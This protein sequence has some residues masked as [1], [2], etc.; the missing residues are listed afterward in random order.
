LVSINYVRL[1][2]LTDSELFWLAG[3]LE[4]EGSFMAPSPSEP[5]SPSVRVEMTDRDVIER[6]CG[7]FGTSVRPIRRPGS[8]NKP[9]YRAVVKGLRAVRLMQDLTPVMGRRRRDQ[10]TAALAGYR[11]PRDRGAGCARL[12]QADVIRILERW[13][14]GES[15]KVLEREYDLSP[16]YVYRLADH[17]PATLTHSYE[18]NSDS[19][20]AWLAGLIEGEGWIGAGSSGHARRVRLSVA[21]TDRDVIERAA[22]LLGAERIRTKTAHRAHWADVYEAEVRGEK[23]LPV[24]RTILPL[25][26]ERRSAKCRHAIELAQAVADDRLGGQ[27]KWLRR[28]PED[29][30]RQA[31]QRALA[32]ESSSVIADDL[33][34]AASTV[35]AIKNGRTQYYREVA[36]VAV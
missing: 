20:V 28:I 32:G 9:S 12:T 30:V 10:I 15:A 13:R 21:M 35:R 27:K 7:L 4:G 3:L 11:S 33:G 34:I 24:L 26:G 1:I 14:N 19:S 36:V 31:L 25:L 8:A 6:A 29:V 5:F 2:E 18:W 22:D 23:A 17:N 16:K